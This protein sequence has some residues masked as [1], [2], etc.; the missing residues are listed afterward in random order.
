MILP[1]RRRH[2]IWS[3]CLLAGALAVVAVAVAI[4]APRPVAARQVGR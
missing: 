4:R 2:I 3:C 1:L